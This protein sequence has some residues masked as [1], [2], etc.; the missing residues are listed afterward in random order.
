MKHEPKQQ[1]LQ[2]VP[3]T[4]DRLAEAIAKRD[5][6]IKEAA[7]LQSRIGALATVE[8]ANNPAQAEL[9][10]PE[11]CGSVSLPPCACAGL[12]VRASHRSARAA[13]RRMLAYFGTTESNNFCASA[14]FSVFRR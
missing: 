2:P 14:E 12:F 7:A 5:Q 8:E 10:A 13:L 9:A 1:Q 3:S 11:R 4:R 6:S